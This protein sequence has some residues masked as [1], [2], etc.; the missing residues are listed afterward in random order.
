MRAP[1]NGFLIQRS[2][3]PALGPAQGGDESAPWVDEF[4]DDT[5]LYVC[6]CFFNPIEGIPNKPI[7]VRCS[8]DR[9]VDDWGLGLSMG[10]E[11]QNPFGESRP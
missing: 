10:W 8:C 3:G 6:V 1:S 9:T 7:D 11:D 2:G 5:R 4:G